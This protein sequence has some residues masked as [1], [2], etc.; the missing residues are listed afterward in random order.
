MLNPQTGTQ[1][2]GS[3][4]T[5]NNH[6]DR[7]F[8]TT[9]TP[10][11]L[12][13]QHQQTTVAD[14]T[15]YLLQH[16][17]VQTKLLQTIHHYLL[18][19]S[20]LEVAQSTTA[21]WLLDNHYVVQQAARQIKQ[22]LPDT[23]YKQLPKLAANDTYAGF[24][25]IYL[26]ARDYLLREQCQ[27][28]IAQLK[29][30]F[31]TY[32][33]ITP[34]TMGEIW[35]VPIMLRFCLLE[36]L[37]QTAGSITQQ[38]TE[39]DVL[40]PALYF[41]LDVDKD[42]IAN[43]ILSLRLLDSQDWAVF[44]EDVSLVEQ[45]LRQDP[46][47][48]YGRMT[49][50]TRDK[51]RK[52]VETLATTTTHTQTEVARTAVELARAASP[53]TPANHDKW[54]GLQ[55]PTTH[56]G[57]YL[58]GLAHK[59]LEQTV[60]YRANFL[61]RWL[62]EHTMAVYLGSILL[63]TFLLIT[64]LIGYTSNVGDTWWQLLLV[65]SLGI[66]P[67]SA[68]A[69]SLVNW[70]VTT[71]VKPRTL[72]KLDFSEG[73]PTACRTMVVIPALLSNEQEIHSLLSQLEQHFLRNPDPQL[74][75]ALLSD[76][77]DAPEPHRAEDDGL[78]REAQ[79]GIRALNQRYPDQ[80]FYLF[81]RRHLYNPCEEVWMGWERKRGKLHEFNRLLRG[82]K[83]T[84]FTVQEGKL[85]FLSEVKY[86]ITLD[87]DTILPLDT[88]QQLIG[89]LAHPLNQTHYDPQT[90]QVIAGYTILQPRT[91]IKPADAARSLF[92]RVFTGDIGLDLY[93]RAVSD[94]YQDLFGEGIYVGKG[95]YD[96]DA[97]EHSLDGRVP[98]NALLS[99]DLFEGIHGRAA[100]VT[101][102]VLYEDFPP[103]YLSYVHRSHRWIRGDW[104]L[105]PWVWLT[106]PSNEGRRR[107]DLPFLARWKII[108]N[109][110]RSLVS[111]SL[112]LF[113]IAGWLWL[114]GPAAAW[115][116]FGLLLTAVPMIT[117]VA[118]ATTRGLSGAT[119]REVRRP[120]H[121]GAIRWLLQIAFL[122]Y[123]TLLHL[124]AI[125]STL[126]RLF[127]SGH[128][129]LRWTTSAHTVR[130]VGKEV[131]AEKMIGQM[132]PS[133]LMAI[134]L[135]LI[136][137][138]WQPQ[139]VGAS[140]PL[141][142]L[143]VLSAEIAHR[144]SQPSTSKREK[145]TM[146][147]QRRLHSLA[148]RTWLFFEEFI[149]PEDNWLPPDHYQE[150]PRGVVAHRTS[151]TNIGLYLLSTLAA[152]DLGYISLLN[153][154]LRLQDTFSTLDKL[155]RHRGHFLNWINTL[156]LQPLPP[157]YVSTVDSG[158]LAGCLLALKQGCLSIKEQPVWRPQRWQGLLDT[159]SLFNEAIADLANVADTAPVADHL[160]SLQR[161]IEAAK[162]E[163][164][165]WAPLLAQLNETELP[166]LEQRLLTFFQ[167]EDGALT[168]E[169]VH[170]WRVYRESLYNNIEGMG[171]ELKLVCPW[172]LALQ[173]PPAYLLAADTPP[174][175]QT[176]WQA[177]QDALPLL[178]R[179]LKLI[180][181]C[182]QAETALQQ[183]QDVVR[184]QGESPATT[185]TAAWCAAL[186]SN[187]ANVRL[188]VE[189][190][191]TSYEMLAERA[192]Q[193]VNEMDFTF[194]LNTRRRVFHIGYNLENGRLD[195]NFYD[196]LASEARIASIVAI[197]K[198]DI[199]Q[200]HWLHL[201]R[202]LTQL[203]GGLG[204]LSWSG[205]MFE[206]LM[207]PLLMHSYPGTL[208]N[209]SAQAI[210]DHQIAYCEDQK[211]PWGIS[212]SGFYIFD[213]AQNYQYRAFGVP[214]AGFKRGLADDLVITPY[215]S[216]MALPIR[217]QAVMKNLDHLLRYQMM[218][219][220]GLYEAIDFTP[221]R[222]NLGQKSAI[223][224]SYMSH[225]QGM[226]MLALAD[227][228]QKDVMVQ[229]FHAEPAIQS[230]ELLLQ[231]Q[232]PVH[233]PLQSP[234]TNEIERH[235]QL[236]T[237]TITAEPWSVPLESPVP[238]VHHLSNGRFST[239]ITNAGSGY[240]TYKDHM[241]TRW[242][243]DTTRDDWGV[244]LYLQDKDSGAHWSVGLQPV[245]ERGPYQEIRYFPHKAQFRRQ[246]H[247]ITLQ[248]EITVAP[249][250]DAEIRLV[251]LT[252]NTPRT[253]H[254]RLTSYGEVVLTDFASDNRHP[255]FA[256]LF[257][258]SEYIP[259]LNALFFRRRPRSSTEKP[260][261]LGHMLVT[262]DAVSL[263]GAYESDRAQFLGRNHDLAHP[264]ALQPEAA[265]TGTTGATLDPIMA[266]GQDMELEAHSAVKLAW[267]TFTADTQADLRSRAQVFQ[268]WV[269]IERAFTSARSQ[270]EQDL[271]RLNLPVAKLAQV[272]RLLS[273]LFYPY[274]AVRAA[275]TTLAANT[276]GQSSLWGYGISGDYPILLLHLED[277]TTNELLPLL[278]CAH[279]YWR[280]RGLL[281]DLVLLNQQESNYGQ[282]VQG[283]ILRTIRRLESEHWLN[284][285]GGIFVLRTDQMSQADNILLH[286]AARVVLD[287]TGGSLARQL[288]PLEERHPGLP[289][290]LPTSTPTA[291][292]TMMP[293]VP[294]PGNLL[295]D[296]GHGGFTSDGKEYVIYLEAETAT[297]APWINV[298]ANEHFGFLISE[299]GSGYSWAVNSGENR[300]TTWR[301]DPVSDMP[302][303]ALYLR[304]EETA[305]IW[306][307]TPQPAPA[308]APYLVRHGAGY[309]TFEHH[310][311]LLKH[312]LRLFVSPDQ[313]VKIIQLHL[314]NRSDQPRR[315]TATYFA[316]WVLGTDRTVTQS[317]IIPEYDAE[318]HALL[319]RNPYNTEFGDAVAFLAAS[320]EPHGFTGDRAE[321]LGHWGRMSRPAAL[322]RIG[323]SDMAPV[324]ADPCAAIQLHIDLAPGATKEIYFLL[325]EGQDEAKALA[326]LAQF[327]DE[328]NVAAAWEATQT[329]WDKILG[330]VTVDTPDPAMNLL[331]NRWL[332]YQAL[333]CR[334]WGRSA[335][336]QSSGAYGFRDQLQDVMS[337]LYARPDLAREHLLR[338][339]RHQFEA[340]DVL[341]WW[342]PPSG[343]GVRTRITD[344]LVWLPYVTAVYIETTGDTAVLDETT[345]FLTGDPLSDD[346]EERYGLY[347]HTDAAY[348]LY[349]HCCRVLKRAIT[350][351]RNN[352]PLMG[353]GDW[354]D[355]MNRVGIEGEGE[356]I[357]LGWFLAATLGA[358]AELCQQC[359]DIKLAEEFRQQARAYQAAIEE[360]G[361]DGQWYR[362]AYY[363]DGS[364]LGSQQNDEC[365]LDAIAQSWAL[366]TGLG[367]SERVQQAMT[368]VEE[369]LIKK[370]ERLI[371]LFAPPFDQTRKDP[372][373]I[374][375]YLPGIRE[376][377]GQYTHAALWT[378]WAFAKLGAADKAAALFKLINPI[379]RADTPQ[380]AERYKVEPYVISAD[381]YGVS[382]H[383]GRGG[384][385]WYTGSSGW[386]Y[387][388]GVEGILGLCR[389]GDKLEIRPCIPDEW[390]GYQISY[391]FG[392]T[393]YNITVTR[394]GPGNVVA[395]VLLD[396]E[397]QPTPEIPLSDDGQHQVQILL[398][399]DAG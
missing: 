16:L 349:E 280:R 379:Y 294:R 289:P 131:M 86:V 103:H 210:I 259:E 285:R 172:L 335:L 48:L 240:L 325:G 19:T 232:L 52:V 305:E 116:L 133:L 255:A 74:G 369:H 195:N 120:L 94:V 370:E 315:L 317:F 314:E 126:W 14:F 393:T 192:Q 334:I 45:I 347:E 346:D 252:N 397:S 43:C 29:G 355:G 68:V 65:A 322:T 231:E 206:Y 160:A 166:E 217:P 109:L 62:Q 202:P 2:D 274:T 97:F 162:H 49:F 265:L 277:E 50:K 130:L 55:H 263:T 208:L 124:D 174:S 117:A 241:L 121:D 394:R 18:H 321:F 362:R 165:Q 225:H 377:G 198:R 161:Q 177:V 350:Q 373:Y 311:H 128:H 299:T 213:N 11:H 366:L 398:G 328:S 138:I 39:E 78:L 345:T 26:I 242:R 188:T 235:L 236:A 257:V 244:W 143:W 151:P 223:V 364:P 396:N 90:G 77:T 144:I 23:Y 353:A 179:L 71:F 183:L 215:A 10:H 372:G 167:H 129:L 170:Q 163:P 33:E 256:K 282:P 222:L 5:E 337:L 93:S 313:A 155:D 247:E 233:T 146:T 145:L 258:E 47:Q 79:T 140:V 306:S 81:H 316:E 387:R 125:L 180:P 250:T 264:A 352:L 238:L 40:A 41:P 288:A 114:P 54:S 262:A 324:G 102:I 340:G 119:W 34:L 386:M 287:D 152:Y 239:L 361:W 148:R 205:T 279:T 127:F 196:L 272:Q 99:H 70:L 395:Q 30:F 182:R 399:D 88:A 157:R 22:D 312:H 219:G 211:L 58:L 139:A 295:F 327:Q 296:N 376:N 275:A 92:T 363:D 384:W 36:C 141:M 20:Q 66:I 154:S 72:P 380:K 101:D 37:A 212:E 207:P 383:E 24:P 25:R 181:V 234:H 27:A 268:H 156:T 132:V 304:D 159:F 310:S 89:T 278:L 173:N 270:A 336:Y 248:M 298:I 8:T 44:F 82:A 318:H 3:S 230:V 351:G 135:L 254:L 193:F 218:G 31:L 283:Y 221:S 32:Q 332:L 331:L 286:T 326:L 75:F 307:P 194:L 229:R 228:L 371:L 189:P 367:D 389:R 291:Q 269:A 320:K 260:R 243:P 164:L 171:R 330:T 7:P 150:S 84:S 142:M 191:L 293:P 63:L 385:T 357:W 281:I 273:L 237:D 96:I 253:R 216:L 176:A 375:G 106:V 67:V 249:D 175:V 308:G 12:A 187:L 300:L 201:A 245:K 348:S 122:P 319:A 358:F 158:N 134:F 341:H 51:Y 199:P 107:N 209:Q 95:I 112:F 297:P 301:N 388:L 186:K 108:D 1:I 38:W 59:K 4:R 15:P 105:L 226:I 184:S 57:N 76:F 115:T 339:A 35:A 111:P 392:N 69:V 60:G 17:P 309:T 220:Y 153:L 246:D 169:T 344:D 368:A 271:R 13:Q 374:K 9:Q 61:S 381:V 359:G 391:R 137:V 46:A 147:E 323:L 42:I 85:S 64:L 227:Y 91:E 354:N 356:S 267:V 123:E 104:Q 190:L 100:L 110:R 251:H 302:S 276:E 98:E 178:P 203:H 284:K 303:E 80:P 6:N 28:N 292:S 168:A 333:A 53:A 342:H 261:F 136:L 21:E 113:F 149:D 204:L 118:I 365:R 338:S 87:A 200:Q 290:F 73:I 185:E 378:I 214:G 83:D 343:R 390:P 56:V 266:L 382:P 329:Q 224:R 360:N 197:A